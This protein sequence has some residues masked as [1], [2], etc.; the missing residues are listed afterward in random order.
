M[1]G[2]ARGAVYDQ[3]RRQPRSQAW[4]RN[5][6]V[7]GLLETGMVDWQLQATNR[8]KL[9]WLTQSVGNADGIY[10]CVCMPQRIKV[11]VRKRV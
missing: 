4:A 2:L 8:S 11:A 9:N 7:Q 5:N 10:Y 1:P 3:P 6:V